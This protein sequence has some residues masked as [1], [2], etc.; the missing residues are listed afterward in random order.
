MADESFWQEL[1]D[2]CPEWYDAVMSASNMHLQK[3]KVYGDKVDPYMNFKLGAI[4]THTTPLDQ[5]EALMAKHQS[6]ITLWRG[7]ELPHNEASDDSYIDRAVYGIINLILYR[8]EHE[9]EL[10]GKNYGQESGTGE[11]KA[12]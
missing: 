6:A 2:T 4:I 10:L 11:A 12:D 3:S 9:N 8:R 5:G 1:K 7:R